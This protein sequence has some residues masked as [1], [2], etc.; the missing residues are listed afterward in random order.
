MDLRVFRRIGVASHCRFPPDRLSLSVPR[1][2]AYGTRFRRCP[3][4]RIRL[5]TVG[6]LH[7]GPMARDS[8]EGRSRLDYPDPEIRREPPRQGITTVGR[9]TCS[10]I[11]LFQAR[12]GSR[13]R[14]LTPCF[15]T[16]RCYVSTP[17]EN[18]RKSLSSPF[19]RFPKFSTSTPS[20]RT[21]RSYGNQS[22]LINLQE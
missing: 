8:V 2:D 15:V 13:P 20:W 21:R 10:Y 16:E 17:P 3:L 11:S 14:R 6:K 19:D 4:T 22:S 5:S 9:W 1:R 18:R 7:A 12:R